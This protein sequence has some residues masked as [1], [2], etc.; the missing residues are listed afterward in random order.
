MK[1]TATIY[2]LFNCIYCELVVRRLRR[3]KRFKGIVSR[4]VGNF[5]YRSKVQA[6]ATILYIF[7]L[8]V[9][10]ANLS[11]EGWDNEKGLKV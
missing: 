1:K 7:F 3:S 5:T 9:S 8:I 11:S 2:F 6:V 10:T 4:A